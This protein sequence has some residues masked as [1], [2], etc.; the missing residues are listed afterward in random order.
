L[1]LQY[2]VKVIVKQQQL[3]TVVLPMHALAIQ[4]THNLP[5]LETN[6][7]VHLFAIQQRQL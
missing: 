5:Y 6:R 7:D 2:H 4:V 3:L 1:E